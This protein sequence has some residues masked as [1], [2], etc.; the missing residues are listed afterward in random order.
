MISWLCQLLLLMVFNFKRGS[1]AGRTQISQCKCVV[2]RLGSVES[3]WQW[4]V[5]W[6]HKQCLLL[7]RTESKTRWNWRGIMMMPKTA[8]DSVWFWN[9]EYW[10]AEDWNSK[11]SRIMRVM[12]R[13]PVR[14][15]SQI[16]GGS[17]NRLQLP[18][19]GMLVQCGK[20]IW[21]GKG[22]SS[23]TVHSDNVYYQYYC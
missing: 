15:P 14:L 4:G 22:F 10:G 5:G 19:K 11:W 18:A 21:P 8:W 23:N 20:N 12:G 16:C 6:A 9:P 13:A 1:Q 7:H 17:A 3:T 2:V